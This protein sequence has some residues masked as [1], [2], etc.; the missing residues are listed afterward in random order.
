MSHANLSW[1]WQESAAKPK[2]FIIPE[3]EAESSVFLKNI[4]VFQ[5]EKRL[6]T[7]PN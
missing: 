7:Q 3:N 5:S 1:Q 4:R 6:K 2:R